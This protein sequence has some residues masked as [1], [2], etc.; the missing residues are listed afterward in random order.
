VQ[1]RFV[2]TMAVLFA[3]GPALAQLGSPECQDRCQKNYQA[4]SNARKMP[5][6]NCRITMEQ[7]RKDC[8]KKAESAP[9]SGDGLPPLMPAPVPTPKPLPA[10]GSASAPSR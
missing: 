6:S 8:V 3:S 2:L 4:C 7:C 5:E 1:G 10:Q 9:A